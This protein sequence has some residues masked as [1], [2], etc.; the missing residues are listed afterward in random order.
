M[1]LLIFSSALRP[2]Y[3]LQLAVMVALCVLNGSVSPPTES[4]VCYMFKMIL[5]GVISDF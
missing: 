4:V 1:Y 5:L 2:L 3:T